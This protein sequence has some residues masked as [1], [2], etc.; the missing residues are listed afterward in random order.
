MGSLLAKRFRDNADELLGAAAQLQLGESLR[1]RLIALTSIDDIN[2]LRS[3][4]TTLASGI[5]SSG[6]WVNFSSLIIAQINANTFRALAEIVETQDY[7][8]SAD[9]RRS[10]QDEAAE[11]NNRLR[12]ATAT[13]TTTGDWSEYDKLLAAHARKI[14]AGN[15]AGAEEG[16]GNP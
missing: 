11:F 16:T 14:S 10:K 3:E 5:P 4:L 7:L 13:A 6:E 2:Q 1:N 15:A 8:A 9:Q 12:A